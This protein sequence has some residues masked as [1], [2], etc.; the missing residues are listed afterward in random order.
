MSR[1]NGMSFL[2]PGLYW[3]SKQ[4]P[5]GGIRTLEEFMLRLLVPHRACTILQR[6]GAGLLLASPFVFVLVFWV[7]DSGT[8]VDLSVAAAVLLLL[9]SV[10]QR[11]GY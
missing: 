6:A 5:S 2:M 10:L 9:G 8:R 1:N 7:P 4:K 11:I 3:A